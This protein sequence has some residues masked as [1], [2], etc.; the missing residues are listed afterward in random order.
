MA[1]K[2][3]KLTIR[4]RLADG[5]LEQAVYNL[6]H[7]FSTGDDKEQALLLF[8]MELQ[9]NQAAGLQSPASAVRVWVE[10]TD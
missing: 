8:D 3:F 4:R 7:A 9:A 5:S 2:N 10:E 1:N 6:E